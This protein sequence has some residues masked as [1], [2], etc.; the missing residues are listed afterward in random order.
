MNG[1]AA[2][3]MGRKADDIKSALLSRYK[4]A[5]FVIDIAD[6]E[7]SGHIDRC[8]QSVLM[9]AFSFSSKMP[10]SRRKVQRK[11]RAHDSCALLFGGPSGTRTPDQPVMSRS[12]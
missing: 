11:R 12:L 3:P 6:S 8:D 2:D 10:G 7:P 1:A 5:F 4:S 9:P